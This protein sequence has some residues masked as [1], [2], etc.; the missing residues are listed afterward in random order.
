MVTPFQ[1]E[2]RQYVKAIMGGLA[3]AL[4]LLGG[5]LG[6]GLSSQETVGV[7]AAFV[8]GF[9]AVFY[10]PNQA[11]KG[12][13]DDPNL[14]E[15]SNVDGGA[16]SVAYVGRIL[17]VVGVALLVAYLLGV[18]GVLYLGLILLLVG[19]VVAVVG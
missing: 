18:P 17:A 2:V 12:Q 13:P 16:A 7:A 8:A 15:R 10:T 14:S 3:S 1:L 4:A 11:A 9:V 5:A 19:L 6:D